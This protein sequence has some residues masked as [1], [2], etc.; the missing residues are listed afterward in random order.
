MIEIRNYTKD[1]LKSFIENL[2][3]ETREK[4]IE[5]AAQIRNEV[6]GKEVF[7][8]GLIEFTNYCK[9]DCYYCGIVITSYSIHYTKLYDKTRKLNFYIFCSYAQSVFK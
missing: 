1:E 4:L 6:Y 9:N 2:T 7:T 3:D 5:T 8:R